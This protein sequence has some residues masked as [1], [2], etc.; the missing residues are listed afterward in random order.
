MRI[1]AFV[2]VWL[3]CTGFTFKWSPTSKPGVDDFYM[4]E[5]KPSNGGWRDWN[6]VMREEGKQIYEV[7]IDKVSPLDCVRVRAINTT[8]R[9]GPTKPYCEGS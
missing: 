8:G 7:W 9:S 1:I 3:L 6:K 5:F 2:L 4:V